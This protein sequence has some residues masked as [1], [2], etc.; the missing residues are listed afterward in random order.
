MTG[1]LL[2]LIMLVMQKYTFSRLSEKV[3]LATYFEKLIIDQNVKAE[4]RNQHERN[5]KLC[6]NCLQLE[7]PIEKAIRPS[8]IVS[9]CAFVK[10]R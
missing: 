6:E 9:H 2:K 7:L 3:R 5:L 10:M 4:A 1:F 8:S